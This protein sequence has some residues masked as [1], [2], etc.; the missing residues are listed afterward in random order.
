[1][2]F[3]DYNMI[4]E[5]ILSVTLKQARCVMPPD[6]RTKQPEQAA[7]FDACEGWQGCLDIET[8]IL[9]S[10][11]LAQLDPDTQFKAD[12]LLVDRWPLVDKLTGQHFPPPARIQ[13]G[14]QPPKIYDAQGSEVIPLLVALERA[15]KTFWLGPKGETKIVV[16]NADRFVYSESF[17][18]FAKSTFA[19]ILAN[20]PPTQP[21]NLLTMEEIQW[22]FAMVGNDQ[23]IDRLQEPGGE[24]YLM[25]W[26]KA[27]G[28]PF[29][30]RPV[31][32]SDRQSLGRQPCLTVD[33][34]LIFLGMSAAY[35]PN[36]IIKEFDTAISEMSLFSNRRRIPPITPE[37]MPTESVWVDQQANK[38]HEI[39]MQ[40]QAELQQRAN[41]GSAEA[42][43]ELD[44][45]QQLAKLRQQK[46]EKT[47]RR[48]EYTKLAIEGV[49]V[50]VKVAQVGS[51]AGCIIC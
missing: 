38:A 39:F 6:A 19:Y 15:C 4:V 20:A 14:P 47:K 16:E 7:I 35:D 27:V 10:L 9:A 48:M 32:S 45:E 44:K 34:W 40:A 33:A 23:W 1:M 46:M 51:K 49:S 24:E 30:T 42:K 22:W 11:K 13:Y 17:T 21:A 25:L 31:I 37:F 12:T 29:E 18:A 3:V 26:W 41:A 2:L 43:V 50:A 8:W 5:S 28:V 36:Y